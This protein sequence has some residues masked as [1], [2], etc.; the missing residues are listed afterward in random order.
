MT[1]ERD[2]RPRLRLMQP[3]TKSRFW[4]CD[5]AGV[6]AIGVTPVTAYKNWVSTCRLVLEV[7]RQQE[8]RA[9][10]HRGLS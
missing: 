3:V 5:G 4:Q 7:H 8:R 10:I 6:E 2:L 1:A 9:A